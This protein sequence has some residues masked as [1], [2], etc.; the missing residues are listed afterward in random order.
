MA[1]SPWRWSA[2]LVFACLWFEVWQPPSA[3]GQIA[4][5]E[6]HA[7]S[8]MTLTDKQFL[9]GAKDGKPVTL[10]GELRIPPGPGKV[11]AIVLLQASGGF[12]SNL[13][14]W[15]REFNG[16]G[17]ATF[18]VDSFTGRG[19]E[20][21]VSDQDQLGR[22][23]LTFDAYRALELLAKHPRIDASRIA[24][25]GFSRGGAAAR[26]ASLKRFQRMYGPSGVEFAAYVPFYADC[27]T[28]YIGDTEVSDK[29]ILQLHGAADDYVP[30]APCRAYFERLKG[31]G[32][33]AVL[34]EYPDAHHV[35]DY[36]M[37]SPTPFAQPR[38]QTTRNCVLKEEPAGEVINAKTGKPFTWAVDPCVELGPHT[39]YNSAATDAAA[40]D[41]KSFLRAALNLKE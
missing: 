12:G 16:M 32:R 17:I 11:P 30:V 41:V 14:R 22:L 7:F 36:A 29:P 18:A 4:R 37:L 19:I 39:G 28:T 6:V 26:F 23:A 38:N 8:S 5:L 40:A 24:L 35:F 10:A 13:D 34:R 33:N 31:A 20:T 9:L 1:I 25:M 15:F 3:Q 21:T 27:G 2:T